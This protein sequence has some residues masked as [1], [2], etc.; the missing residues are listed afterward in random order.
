M[1]YI[2]VARELLCI[3]VIQKMFVSVW[4]FYNTILLTAIPSIVTLTIIVK[5]PKSLK[6]VSLFPP[7]H[8]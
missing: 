5:T 4:K 7:V 1:R 3:I 8:V 2:K 6:T